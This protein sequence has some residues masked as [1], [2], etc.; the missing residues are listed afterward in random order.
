MSAKVID[1]HK[2]LS[3]FMTE[4]V[5]PAESDYERY[6][7]E[8]GP[9]DHTVPPIIEELKIRAKELGLWNLFL[10]AESGLTNLEYAPLAELT[11][12]SLEI[13]PEALNCAAPDTGNMEILH[14]FGTEEQRRQWLQPLLDGEIRSAFS[15]T[16]PAVA[17]SDARNIETTI[18]R[19]GSDYVINGRKWWTSGASDPRCKI[20]IVMGRTNPAA[21][22]HQQQSMILVPMDTPGVRV[23]RST[24]VFGWQD[25]HGHCEVSYDDVRVPATNLLGE[26]GS[27]FAIA[28]ARLGPGRIHH[29]MRALGG[30]ERALALM[31]DRARNRVAFGRP[32]ADQGVVQQAIAKSRNEIDQARLLCEKAA[33]TIDQHGNKEARH[34]VA[35]IKAVA[36]Q[37]ACDVIDR[38]IQ[39]HG[40]AG[41]SDDTP[42]ARLYSWH[43]A[44]RIF[45]GPDEVHLRSIAR[46]ELGREK[47]VLA[48]AATRHG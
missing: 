5:F 11:G 28:Q 26:E 34:L 4:Y 17:S 16:E 1:Y 40:A 47:S 19:D 6:R 48:A 43:R 8:A 9:D 32:L 24:P 15:M 14:M 41:V 22:A 18:S 33:W 46:A 3:S 36:P 2:R 29:C 13:A 39:I 21:A 38:A 10:P 31:V 23:I 27:G 12:W 35:M 37:V 42:L 7:R 20:L 45:D 25:Q 30:A 44:M